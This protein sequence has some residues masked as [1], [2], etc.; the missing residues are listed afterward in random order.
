[1]YVVAGGHRYG[2]GSIV[3]ILLKSLKRR[4][5]PVRSMFSAPLAGN[6]AHHRRWRVISVEQD[7]D[8]QNMHKTMIGNSVGSEKTADGIALSERHITDR[9]ISWLRVPI[10]RCP[11]LGNERGNSLPLLLCNGRG[12]RRSHRNSLLLPVLAETLPGP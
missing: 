3:L 6:E 9:A 10:A 2:V 7:V 12:A 1:M 4:H 8:Q 5:G 11:R